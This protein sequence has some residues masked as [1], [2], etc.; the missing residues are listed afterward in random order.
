M[1]NFAVDYVPILL[2]QSLLT[3]APNYVALQAVQPVTKHD[4]AAARTKLVEFN[5]F[6][7]WGPRGW[8]KNQRRRDKLQVLGTANSEGLSS[9]R[10]TLQI[11][12]FT[13]PSRDNGDPSSLWITLEDMLY[14]RINLMQEGL[15][16]WHES[17]GSRNM[18]DD[19]TGFMDRMCINETLNTTVKLN[20][21]N[22]ADA[23]VLATD[24]ALSVD[25]DRAVYNLTIRNTKAFPD[26][27]YHGLMD[28]VYMFHLYQDPEFKQTAL[29]LHQNAQVPISTPYG[30]SLLPS[31]LRTATPGSQV[32]S[33]MPGMGQ[34]QSPLVPIL[35]K[36]LL[37]YPSNNMPKRLINGFDA[38]LCSVFGPNTVAYGSGGRG[39]RMKIHND[40]DYN[41]HFR[42]IWS[43][44]CDMGYLPFDNDSTG[45]AVELR[46]FGTV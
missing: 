40:T 9:D 4:F 2:G 15:A 31:F 26:G 7:R 11:G 18:A 5:Q 27:L 44:F 38:S 29:A 22:K 25:L 8:T 45:C 10:F 37:L 36:N 39:V 13:G 14:S 42:Y 20:P 30:Q 1:P 17:I 43:H 23:A 35:Y 28:L 6:K 32:P 3:R 46:S 34:D 33:G 19:Y 41:R 21:G 12:E 16:D 24:K